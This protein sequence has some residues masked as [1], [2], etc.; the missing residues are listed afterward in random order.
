MTFSTH[1]TCIWFV[2]KIHINNYNATYMEYINNFKINNEK[3]E[4]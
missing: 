4:I 1:D 2:F 3:Y